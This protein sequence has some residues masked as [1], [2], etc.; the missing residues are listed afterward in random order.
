M[1]TF[2][3]V[4]G[5][6]FGSWIWKKI[7]PPM[8][9]KGHDVYAI[10]LTGMG[11]RVHLAREEYGMETAI[12]DVVKLL[13]Y[14]DLHDVVL[15]GHSFAGKVISTVYDRVPDR[16]K[17]LFYL[18]AFVPQKT[19]EP[20]GGIDQMDKE[21]REILENAVKAEG[22]GW[23][24]GVPDE[25]LDDLTWD[26]KGEE[27]DWFFSK[28]TPWPAKLAFESIQVSEKVDRAKKAYIFC[29]RDWDDIKKEWKDFLSSLEGEYRLLVAAHYPMVTKAEET[30]D[31]LIALSNS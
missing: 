15:V 8:R 10:T 22:S 25:F 5:A 24:L 4:H 13:E 17:L 14:E 6:W 1:A 21:E 12:Q 26:L 19:R 9:E 31:A 28:L 20:Q 16:I 7:M 18:D 2:V 27:K 30:L 11:D 23:K 3:F 29:N